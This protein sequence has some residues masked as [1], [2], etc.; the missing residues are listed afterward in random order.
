MD[1]KL[2][3]IF[4]EEILVRPE[5]EY[6]FNRVISVGMESS[7]IILPFS[8]IFSTFAASHLLLAHIAHTKK[9]VMGE[10]GSTPPVVPMTGALCSNGK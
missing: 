7:F 10:R 3:P 2:P 5:K 8:E 4:T 1:F 6:R 9:P